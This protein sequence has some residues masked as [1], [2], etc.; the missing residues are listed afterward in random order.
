MPTSEAYLKAIHTPQTDPA[1]GSG[2]NSGESSAESGRSGIRP[3]AKSIPIGRHLD[4]REMS[5]PSK[6]NAPAFD[7]V[8]AH[9]GWARALAASLVRDP[10]HADDLVQRTWIAAL[11]HPPGEAASVKRWLAAVMRNFAR[12]DARSEE[13]RAAREVLGA[14]AEALPPHDEVESQAELQR[15]LLDA[16]RALDEPYRSTIWARYYEGLPPR[17]I[18]KRARVPVKTVKTRLSRGLQELRVRFDR[19]HGG[20]RRAWAALLIPLAKPPSLAGAA[21]GGLLVNTQLKIATAV[22]ILVGAVAVWK[23]SSNP[24]PLAPSAAETVAPASPALAD[25]TRLAEPVAPTESPRAAAVEQ[26]NAPPAPATPPHARVMHGRVLDL[27]HRPVGGIDVFAFAAQNSVPA[28]PTAL[29]RTREDGTFETPAPTT[30]G[31]YA[32]RGASWVTVFTT[33]VWR[34]EETQVATI[35]VA[36]RCPLAGA[37]VDAARHPI[38]HAKVQIV[39]DPALRRDLG[40]VMGAAS[41]MACEAITDDRGRFELPDAPLARGKL[42]VE[43]AGWM[44]KAIEPPDRATYDLEIAL[45]RLEA[46]HAIVVGHVVDDAHQPVEGA[47]VVLGSATRMTPAD[48]SFGFDIDAMEHLGDLEMSTNESARPMF[49][50]STITAAKAGSLPARAT[51]P[52]REE[53][54]AA[55]EPTELTL[56]LG[57]MPLEIRGRVV[58]ADG[59]PVA[60]AHVQTSAETPFGSIED[61]RSREGY[62]IDVSVEELLRGGWS[63][64]K[65]LSKADGSFVL[66]GLLDREY[67]LHALD[68]RTLRHAQH[69]AV[70]AGARDVV[71]TLPSEKD[72]VRVAGRVVSCS[73]EPIANASVIIGCVT[74]AEKYAKMVSLGARRDTDAQGRFEFPKIATRDVAFQV[75]SASTFALVEWRPDPKAALDDLEIVASR[76]CH[77]QVDLGDRKTFADKCVVLDAAGKPVKMLAN[78]GHIAWFPPEIDVIDGR[79]EALACEE[80]GRTIVF[81]KAG[82]EVTRMPIALKPGEL[83]TVRP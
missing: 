49:D 8:L 79:S 74:G 40:S 41:L 33:N 78:R 30:S 58:D 82:A 42:E 62:R 15:M 2:D 3:A 18:A 26:Q 50:I 57:G 25:G 46:K 44:T 34:L 9:A 28:T 61:I 68:E 36:P 66:G 81:S 16:V 59:R 17:E 1:A 39:F 19:E 71:I 48:G 29:A 56:V 11:E 20:D 53:L 75:V 7:A 77:V 64:P 14:R 45:E 83:V 80:T 63:A 13:R 47:Y 54:R 38:A 5:T 52:S 43:A 31:E 27:E 23:V 72:C 22:V 51:V 12:Q 4:P 65:V 10:Q 35:W 32:A 24:Q 21:I 55:P 60:G 69:A 37:V 73:G 67:V 76:L 70:H 6:S